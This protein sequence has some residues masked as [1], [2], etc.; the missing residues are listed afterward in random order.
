MNLLPVT[1]T[2][3]TCA[4]SEN[5][6]VA[7]LRL[8]YLY[9]CLIAA[10]VQTVIKTLVNYFEKLQFQHTRAMCRWLNGDSHQIFFSKR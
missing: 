10:N 1:R 7:I 9:T 8:L 4:N 2:V 5:N 3:N 6:S